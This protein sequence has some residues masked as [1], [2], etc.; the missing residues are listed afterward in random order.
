MV[1]SNTTSNGVA[2]PGGDETSRVVGLL[3]AFDSP[4]VLRAAAGRIRDEGFKRWD[5]HSPFPIH[6]M[7][8]AMGIRPTP[9]PWLVLLAGISGA[10]IAIGMQWWTNAFDYPYLISG[11]PL[12]SLPANI[13][14]TFEVIVLLSALTAFG[15]AM[16]LNQ[17]PQFAHSVFSSRRF[18]QATSDGFFISIEAADAKFD[19]SATLGLL[20][21]LGATA[22]ETCHAT[23]AGR[24]FPNALVWLAA[25]LIAL[26]ALP[27]A[28]IARARLTK[29]RSPRIH[30]IQDM[31]FQPKYLAQ[32]RSRLFADG[33]AMRPR[34]SGTVQAGR[35]EDDSHFYRG[36]IEEQWATTFPR[37]VTRAMARR[38]Q[39]RFGIYC[40]PC[41]GLVGEGGATA[42]VSIRALER[43]E[44]GWVPPLSLHAPTV[45]EQP[46]GQ[47]FNTITHGIRTMP[48]HG[49]QIPEQ[50]RWAIVLYV[51]ALQRS[52][53]SAV[54]DVPEHYRDGLR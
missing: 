26:A 14:V 54:E 30:I 6:A 51:R 33:R 4:E 28:L 25:V 10:A 17:L 22:V 27:P 9:L 43:E 7:E 8:R 50:D 13:P 46:V 39:E 34:S 24:A 32:A 35:P 53:S 40:A 20:E 19:E 18:R 48:G 5:V 52:R 45:V 15:G 2:V 42:M 11:K 36:T 16:A 47:I 29:S 44:P 37:P 31:D 41:H 1:E 38:G 49:A 23:T 3:A 21:S 12:F